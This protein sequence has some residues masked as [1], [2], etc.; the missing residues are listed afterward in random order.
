[1]LLV[2]DI[3]RK[4]NSIR[5]ADEYLKQCLHE[6]EF[7]TVVLVVCGDNPA[8]DSIDF[9]PYYTEYPDIQLPWSDEERKKEAREN[10]AKVASDKVINIDDPNSLRFKSPVI[11]IAGE[12]KLGGIDISNDDID[13]MLDYFNSV[14]ASY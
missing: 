7:Y 8:T 11:R 14:A 4:G 3:S 5:I 10:L 6:H 1:M 13:T 9:N 12:D 2:D